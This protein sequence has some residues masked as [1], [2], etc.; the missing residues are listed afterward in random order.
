MQVW[1]AASYLH[2]DMGYMPS[3]LLKVIGSSTVY[4]YLH[5]HCQI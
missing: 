2:K 1:N 3:V 5:C 4:A